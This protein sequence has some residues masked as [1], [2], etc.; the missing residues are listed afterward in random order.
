MRSNFDKEYG[1]ASVGY[2]R[3]GVQQSP[4]L[5][6]RTIAYSV[7]PRF[8]GGAEESTFDH[9]ASYATILV[10]S[11]QKLIRWECWITPERFR[12]QIV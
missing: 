1:S 3:G 7:E 12:P 6:S 8:V 2:T 9:P 5:I 11:A 4:K 10:P